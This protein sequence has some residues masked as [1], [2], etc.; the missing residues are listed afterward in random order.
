M[1]SKSLLAVLFSCGLI[2]TAGSLPAAAQSFGQPA[3][4]GNGQYGYSGSYYGSGGD[5]YYQGYSDTQLLN[6]YGYSNYGRLDGFR[7][8]NVST[9]IVIQQNTNYYYP[10]SNCTTSVAGSPIPLPYAR[11]SRTGQI[12]R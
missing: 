4:Y 10:A 8:P 2:E 6:G 11:D 3:Y 12:C 5:Q 9:T 1:L 7:Q